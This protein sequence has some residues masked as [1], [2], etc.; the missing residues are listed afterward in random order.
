MHLQSTW[1]IEIFMN[2]QKAKKVLNNILQHWLVFGLKAFFNLT[3]ASTDNWEIAHR[4]RTKY[5]ITS[6]IIYD[7]Y[8][9]EAQHILFNCHTLNIVIKV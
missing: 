4:P 9:C 8:G 7:F 2:I 3:D 1:N 5:S 6:S